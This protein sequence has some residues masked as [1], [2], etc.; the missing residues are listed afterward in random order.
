MDPEAIDLATRL[1]GSLGFPIFVA[2]WL[3]LRSDNIIKE[4]TVAVRDLTQ[5]VALLAQKLNKD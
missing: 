2:V 4:M 1:I 5:V 3:L